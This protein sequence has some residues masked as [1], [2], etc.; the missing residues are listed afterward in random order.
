M[1]L[2]FAKKV[3]SG[4]IGWTP[5]TKI[6]NCVSN[7][8][9]TLARHIAVLTEAM[10][11]DAEL[12]GG[13][14]SIDSLPGPRLF[15][16]LGNLEHVKTSFLKI[17]ITQLKDGKKYGP[18]YRDQILATPVI[19]VQDPDLCQEIY[20][21]E[22]KLPERDFA[23]IFEEFM[24]ERENRKLPK[25]L[26]DLNGEE[27]AE[28]RRKFH[29]KMLAPASIKAF[30]PLFSDIAVD[31]VEYIKRLRDEN[32]IVNDIREEVIG[33]WALESIGK[34]VYGYRTGLLDQPLIDENR[35]FYESI[36]V[37]LRHSAT[38]SRAKWM[39]YINRNL[40]QQA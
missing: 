1:R 30:Y 5:S 21:A 14:K 4:L 17:H 29:K 6:Q 2:Q 31:A 22:G 33:K 26:L 23:F 10:K 7:Y 15:P 3:R 35:R 25:S 11:N 32:S 34:F 12:N 39:K 20:R 36:K 16:I 24:E 8:R 19:V 28:L 9:S 37:I 27:W 40:H 38:L 18:M 13:L